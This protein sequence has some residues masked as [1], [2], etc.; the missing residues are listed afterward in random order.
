MKLEGFYYDIE[1]DGFYLDATQIW[2]VVFKDLNNPEKELRVCPFKDPKAKDK[3]LKFL[4]GY[5][6]PIVAAHYGL[7]YDQFMLMKHLGIDFSLT[8]K[9]YTMAGKNVRFVDTFY[10]SMY[11][12]PD[13]E[14]HGIEAWGS[15]L[16]LAKIDWRAKAIELGLVEADSPP[17]SEFKQWHPEMGKYCVRDVE[18]GIRVFHHLMSLF[19]EQYGDADEFPEHFMC[20]QMAFYLMSCQG[21]TGWKF[22]QQ[23]GKELSSTIENMMEE[24]RQEV[25]PQL[26]PRKL[27]KAEEKEYQMPAKPFKMDGTFSSHMIN[28]INKHGGVVNEDGTVSFYGESYKV[29]SKCQLNI[30][31]PMT[32][33]NQDDIKQWLLDEHGWKPTLWN[34]KR[35]PDGK[36]M[37]DEKTRQFIPTTPKMQE[38]GKI[39]D[40]LLHLQGDLVKKIVKW[41][42]LRNRYSVL[43]GWLNN[44]RLAY[45]GRL[46]TDRTGI[47]PTHRQKHSVVVNCPKAS[48]KVLLG[49]E[50]RSLFICEDGMLI[51]AGDASALEGRVEGSYT[52]KYDNGKRASVI[53]DGDEHSNNAKIFYPEETKNFDPNEK[54]FNKDDPRFKPYRDRSKNGRYALTYGCS[55]PK[56]ASTLGKPENQAKKLYEAFW[57]GNPSLKELKTN[58]EKFWETKGQS[59]WIPGIDGR[60]IF[61][62]KKSA[63][64]NSLFQ[65]CGA[66]V[67]DYACCFLDEWLGGIKFDRNF[68]PCYSYK[69]HTVRR[70]GFF[71]DEIEFEC[72]EAVAEEVA[73][74]IEK[75]IAYAGEYLALKVPLAGEGKVGVNWKETH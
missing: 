22:D 62:R 38:A 1:A 20:G 59:K 69:G 41:L 63:L 19:K 53:L 51:A 73:N 35:G 30:K 14:G 16:G 52:F 65:S 57:D 21:F 44:P 42:S 60:R 27:K 64:L 13:A 31:L 40:N 66:I 67:M 61:T 50:F 71:H 17:G 70:I 55:P 28:F 8:L 72:E 15:R 6:N 39:C 45:D 24:I 37:R 10:L 74:M 4:G 68:K 25:E 58:V 26:P 34:Y 36:P 48:D 32:L 33:G 18:V 29:I 56:L 3:I 54:G 11:T 12:N 23:Y 5:D 47:T 75:A 43:Q 9:Q 49:K 46:S 7:G 2:C